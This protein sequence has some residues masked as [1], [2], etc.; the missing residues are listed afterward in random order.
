ME[1]EYKQEKEKYQLNLK[2]YAESDS[3]SKWIQLL[4]KLLNSKPPMNGYQGFVK[5][6]ARKGMTLKDYPVKWKQ[7][8]DHDRKMYIDKYKK[9]YQEWK[10]KMSELY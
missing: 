10:D 6:T 5:E 7:L 3:Q 8:S 1:N 2:E 9:L 4:T